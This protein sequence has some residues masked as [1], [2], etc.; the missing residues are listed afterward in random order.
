[1]KNLKLVPF[2][3]IIICLIFS[4]KVQAQVETSKSPIIIHFFTYDKM[5]HPT[6]LKIPL[7]TKYDKQNKYKDHFIDENNSVYKKIK[8]ESNSDEYIEVGFIKDGMVF[9]NIE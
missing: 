8:N 9:I 2:V 5:D 6:N 3:V 1:M 7:C 4:T